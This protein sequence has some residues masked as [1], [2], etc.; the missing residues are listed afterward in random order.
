MTHI[1]DYNPSRTL[2]EFRLLPGLTTHETKNEDI[3]L[4][5]PLVYSSKQNKK[6]LLNIPIV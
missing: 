1:I 3:S 4:Q 2:M 6:Y 5:T